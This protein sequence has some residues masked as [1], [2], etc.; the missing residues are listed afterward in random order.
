MVSHAD[1]PA[2]KTIENG[3]L[4]AGG[5]QVN[6]LTLAEHQDYLTWIVLKPLL[7][8]EEAIATGHRPPEVYAWFGPLDEEL[9]PGAGSAG[10]DGKPVTDAPKSTLEGGPSVIPGPVIPVPSRF[11]TEL[12]DVRGEARSMGY[13]G[14]VCISCGSTRMLNN[15]TCL[16]CSECGQTT[17]CS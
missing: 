12:R 1:N 13:T 2:P 10:S 6:E 17:G 14:D 7:T 4:V 5:L 9:G 8:R 3:V 11:E 16:V 15:G